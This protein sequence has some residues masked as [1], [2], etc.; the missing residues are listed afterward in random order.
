MTLKIAYHIK[1]S[2]DSDQYICAFY[3]I[4]YT[5]QVD[6]LALNKIAYSVEMAKMMEYC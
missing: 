4:S 3:D 5:S 2:D 1:F 6:N